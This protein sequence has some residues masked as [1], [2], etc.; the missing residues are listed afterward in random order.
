MWGFA[1]C[2]DPQLDQFNYQYMTIVPYIINSTNLGNYVLYL[3]PETWVSQGAQ[4]L[5]HLQ[6]KLWLQ[7]TTYLSHY[8]PLWQD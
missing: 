7:V 1:N 3:E 4:P 2:F 8:S 5:Y 6:A